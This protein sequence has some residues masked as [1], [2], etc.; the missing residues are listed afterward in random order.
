MKAAVSTRDGPPDVLAPES[1][2]SSP[3]PARVNIALFTSWG[4][5]FLALW[6]LI[7]GVNV[8]QWK[9]RARESA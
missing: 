2:L 4:E 7:K 6:L 8:E 5:L 9:K 3:Q 1:S